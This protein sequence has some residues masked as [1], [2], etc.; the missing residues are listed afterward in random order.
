MKRQGDLLLLPVERVEGE[1]SNSNVVLLGEVSG[2]SHKI[3]NGKVYRAWRD[4]YILADEGAEL[5][6]EEHDTIPLSKGAY[7][8]VRQREYI[9]PGEESY[10]YD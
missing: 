2:H 6:H 3:I 5:V 9:A 8:V 1:D 4:I 7:K 10:I